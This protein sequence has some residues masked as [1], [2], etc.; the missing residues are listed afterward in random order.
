M[1]AECLSDVSL[2][3]LKEFDSDFDGYLNFQEFL[4]IFLPAAN[5]NLR[6]NCI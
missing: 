4:N 1:S 3:I 6:K 5:E 2:E